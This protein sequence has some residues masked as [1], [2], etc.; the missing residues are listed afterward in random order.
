MV[1]GGRANDARGGE[2]GGV[3]EQQMVRRGGG[4]GGGEREQTM[5]ELL[6]AA[7]DHSQFGTNGA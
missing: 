5:W 6:Q 2:R 1:G 3:G 7:N 4:M